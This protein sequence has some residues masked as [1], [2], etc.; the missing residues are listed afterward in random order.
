MHQNDLSGLDRGLW[1]Q[2][3]VGGS[4]RNPRDSSRQPASWKGTGA[5][6]CWG[7]CFAVHAKLK[8][9]GTT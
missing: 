3:P 4:A 8:L 7:I 6:H 2:L 9:Q 1:V 5:R